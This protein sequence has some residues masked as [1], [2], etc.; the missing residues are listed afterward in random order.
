MSSLYFFLTYKRAAIITTLLAEE[1]SINSVCERFEAYSVETSPLN[2]YFS[3][4]SKNSSVCIISEPINLKK[5][6]DTNKDD[7]NSNIIIDKFHLLLYTMKNK[8]NKRE[9]E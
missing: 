9:E 2:P 5:I 8:P 3:A 6:C 1:R 7:N 4:L